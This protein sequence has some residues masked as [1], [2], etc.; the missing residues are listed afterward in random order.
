MI[1]EW[2]DDEFK[3][4]VKSVLNKDNTRTFDYE[5]NDKDAHD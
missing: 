5:E 1:G 4:G 3:K 2:A